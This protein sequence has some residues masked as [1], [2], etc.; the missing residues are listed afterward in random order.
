MKPFSVE[1]AC[2]LGIQSEIQALCAPFLKISKQN[3][4][5]IFLFKIHRMI[6]WTLISFWMN[7]M[8]IVWIKKYLCRIDSRTSEIFFVPKMILQQKGNRIQSIV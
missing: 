5:Y 3:D 8:L 7:L 4:Q 2:L 6:I 1:M